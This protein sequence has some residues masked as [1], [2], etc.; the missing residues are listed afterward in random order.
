MDQ[1]L[2]GNAGG[3]VNKTTRNIFIGSKSLYMGGFARDFYYFRIRR[4]SFFADLFLLHRFCRIGTDAKLKL[5]RNFFGSS[6][7]AEG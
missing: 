2:L 3:D 4:R 6:L 1:G 7:S 5:I